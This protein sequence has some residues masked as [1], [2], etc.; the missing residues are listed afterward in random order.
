MSFYLNIHD[1][2]KI[3]SNYKFPGYNHGTV[4]DPDI[5]IEVKKDFNFSKRGLNRL[6]YWFYGKEGGNLVYFEDNLFGIRNK[7]LLENLEGKTEIIV[8]KSVL[9]LDSLFVP[10]SR[11]SFIDLISTVVQIKLIN[12]GFVPIHAACLSKD[13]SGLLLVAFP[14]MGKTLSTLQLLKEGF[15]FIGEDTVYVDNKGNAFFIPTLSAIHYDFLKFFN[16]KKISTWEYYKILTKS[17][18]M[19]KNQFI[20]RIFEPPKIN[21]LD[22]VDNT[23]LRKSKVKNVCSLEI[24]E[25]SIK[26]VDKE[27]LTKKILAINRYSLPRIDTNPF[28]WV[29]SYFN[30]FD[31]ERIME[32]ERRNISAFLDGCKCFSLACNDKDWI[33]VLKEIGVV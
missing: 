11:K 5:S 17:W 3:N 10:C 25:R 23:S 24:G 12:A 9:M 31:I 32:I 7:V 29:Y 20:N 15:K 6:D 19:E 1:M 28:I 14:R 27:C 16:Q 22:M 26:E 8:T 30:G 33:S 2:V 21:L 13:D 4:S 18:I